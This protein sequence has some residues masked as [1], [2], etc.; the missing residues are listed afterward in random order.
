MTSPELSNSNFKSATTK[1]FLIIFSAIK[2]LGSL[3]KSLT[4]VIRSFITKGFVDNEIS[5][6]ENFF[7][8]R[9]FI[10]IFDLIVSILIIFFS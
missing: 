7:L 3:L 9:D 2:S 4:K 6:K 10:E 8:K 5:V 1:P